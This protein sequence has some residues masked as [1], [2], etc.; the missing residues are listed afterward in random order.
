[1]L[2]MFEARGN[3]RDSH[4]RSARRSSPKAPP[5]YPPK[6]KLN[7]RSNAIEYGL[8][9]PLLIVALVSWL[10]CGTLKCEAASARERRREAPEP[11]AEAA[12]LR[13]SVASFTSEVGKEGGG[14][15]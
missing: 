3:E 4:T 10:L 6:P 7:E 12:E 8:F 9:K 5:A 15:G 13:L 14:R 2:Q 1:M 11:R